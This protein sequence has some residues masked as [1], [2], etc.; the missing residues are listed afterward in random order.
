MARQSYLLLSAA[1][2][3]GCASHSMPLLETA[4]QSFT[5]NAPGP[6][7]ISKAPLLENYA[8]FETN[9]LNTVEAKGIVGVA[10]GDAA[11]LAIP[12][13]N[14]MDLALPE[15]DNAPSLADVAL[16]KA[17]FEAVREPVTVETPGPVDLYA[18]ADVPTQDE[19]LAQE[20]VRTAYFVDRIPLERVRLLDP[21]GSIEGDVLV[22]ADTLIAAA[23]APVAVPIPAAEITVTDEPMTFAEVEVAP[24]PIEIPEVITGEAAPALIADA[25]LIESAPA[26][27]QLAAVAPLEIPEVIVGEAAPELLP[28]ANIEKLIIGEVA[29]ALLPP[30]EIPEIIVGQPAPSLMP[31][32]EMAALPSG[33]IEHIAAAATGSNKHIRTLDPTGR[34]GADLLTALQVRYQPDMDL[35]LYEVVGEAAPVVLAALDDSETTDALPDIGDMMADATP[36]E[37]ASVAQPIYA[38]ATESSV[39]A[40][41]MTVAMVSYAQ[42]GAGDDAAPI[43]ADLPQGA[44]PMVDDISEE[45]EEVIKGEAAPSLIED[46]TGDA[47][48]L[49]IA[50]SVDGMDEPVADDQDTI[51]M[52]AE[53]AVAAVNKMRADAGLEPLTLNAQ[54]NEIAQAHVIDLAARGEVSALDRDGKGIGERLTEAGY[55]PQ[56]AGSLVSGGYA[57]FDEALESWNANELQRSRLLME[58]ASDMGFAVI[59]DRRSTYGFYIEAIVAGQ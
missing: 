52:A 29:P 54:L 4:D 6:V 12:S 20:D 13:P 22:S 34:T 39:A 8:L 57:T 55:E 15:L 27:I 10:A 47:S 53:K 7:A 9:N 5:L 58:G 31:L 42:E 11:P 3:T 28:P 59:S 16:A 35:T 56:V 18:E 49:A 38:M 19:R 46:A 14:P 51:K 40:E 2:V 25:E 36:V 33:S 37:T 32:D 23:E 24:T 21:T 50:A 45:M 17:D 48:A 43:T 1:F 41:P 26:E 30:A 44:D